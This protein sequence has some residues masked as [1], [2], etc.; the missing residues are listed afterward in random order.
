[1]SSIP[2]VIGFGPED[3]EEDEPRMFQEHSDD[4]ILESIS[5]NFIDNINEK[6]FTMRW[7]DLMN[8]EF[9]IDLKE[10]DSLL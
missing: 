8:V 9:W 3:E 2:D 4:G 10:T 5:K 6:I 7:M 1:M